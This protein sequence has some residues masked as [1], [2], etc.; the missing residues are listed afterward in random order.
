MVPTTE[1][2]RMHLSKFLSLVL[3]HRPQLIGL[4]LDAEGWADVQ[5]LLQGCAAKGMACTLEQIQEIVATNP[6]Q[7]FALS[8]D[9]QRIRANQGHSVDVALAL[10]PQ[11]P[12]DV[13]YHGTVHPF[14]KSILAQGL[15]KRQ[16]HHVHLSAEWATAEQVGSRRGKPVVLTV[17][18]GR[19]WADGYLFYQSH[20]GVWLTDL[21]PPPYL[22]V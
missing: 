4:T 2:D 7:R 15:Q 17:Q 18:A 1:K 20:N 8:N 12:P 19:M 16:R 5:T 21:V 13:L 22:A 11:Q 6:K 9:S 14:L 10:P 3:R